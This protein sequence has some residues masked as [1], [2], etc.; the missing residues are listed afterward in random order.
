MTKAKEFHNCSDFHR[1]LKE[2]KI[3]RKS[4]ELQSRNFME[5]SMERVYELIRDSAT[6]GFYEYEFCED[7]IKWIFEQL[8]DGMKMYLFDP[9]VISEWLGRIMKNLE[10]EDFTVKEIDGLNYV[11]SW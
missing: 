6:R 10:N 9:K 5:C 2:D 1:D 7:D 3:A 11:I 4:I 8:T